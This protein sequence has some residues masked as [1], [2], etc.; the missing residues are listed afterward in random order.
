MRKLCFLISFF[1]CFA[2]SCLYAQNNVTLTSVNG[3]TF[4]VSIAGKTWNNKLQGS[5]LL[6][7]ILKD[8][9]LIE[10]E[11]EN[12]KKL[13]ATLYLLEQGLPCKNKEFNYKVEFNDV[14]L[15]LYFIGIYDI[16][17]LPNPIVPAKPI[18]DTTPVINN[19]LFE[20]FCEV[21]DGKAIY[22]NNL[23]KT[24]V[25]TT[26]MPQTYLRYTALLVSKAEVQDQ[27]FVV[28]ENVC[29]NNC[30][31]VAQLSALLT[32]IDYEIEK[33]KLIRTAYSNLVDREN[34]KN[35]EKSF[36][37]ESS[38][39]ALNSFFNNP[40]EI[41]QSG[42]SKCTVAASEMLISHYVER[43][44][45]YGTDSERF[46]ALKKGY[47]DLCYSTNQVSLILTKFIH[48]REKLDASK[49]LYFNCVEKSTFM[50]VAEVFSYNQTK[51]ELK[52][53]L[54]KQLK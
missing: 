28:V 22:F 14:T 8:T 1:L 20:H 47:A 42:Q 32:Y 54:E 5:V 26:A 7:K 30:L 38:I 34:K 33:L 46:E 39:N 10:L 23:P 29:R 12:K 9:L 17:P 48:D 4:K 11:F 40:A 53:F 25:C 19:N 49:L 18:R 44:S 6:E 41:K 13:P 3:K 2:T 43:L 31:N 37:F 36:R 50:N 15:K 16:I 52:D 24:G 21:K 51:S 35:L 27:K 45:S